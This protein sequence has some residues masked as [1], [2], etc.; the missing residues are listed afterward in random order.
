M[1]IISKIERAVGLT[2]KRRSK[3][4][5]KAKAKKNGGRRTPPRRADGRFKRRS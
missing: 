3:P 4:K 1:G 2:K 5:A